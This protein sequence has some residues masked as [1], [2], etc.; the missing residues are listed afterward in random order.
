MD[1]SA[2]ARTLEELADILELTDANPFQIM[3][4]RNGALN[5]EDWE[6]DLAEAVE[7]KTLTEL[8]GIGKGL[9]AIISELHLTDSSEECERIRALVPQTLTDL[10]KVPRLGPKRARRLHQ[11]LGVDSLDALEEAAKQGRIRSLKGFGSKSEERI[12]RGIDRARRYRR[13]S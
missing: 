3:A 6:G 8:P 9:A 10:L 11:E 4:Y 7:S 5:L 13:I 2:I 1:K 12:M